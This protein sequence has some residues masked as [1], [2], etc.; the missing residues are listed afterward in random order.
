MAAIDSRIFPP[1]WRNSEVKSGEIALLLHLRISQ[2]GVAV[3]DRGSSASVIST[4]QPVSAV[5]PSHRPRS[6][7]RADRTLVQPDQPADVAVVGRRRRARGVAVADLATVPPQQP[8]D[9]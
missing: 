6:V 4:H 9:I 1:N 2:A 5:I 3:D 8:A 7:A